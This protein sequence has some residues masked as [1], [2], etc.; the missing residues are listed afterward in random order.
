[1]NTQRI[2]KIL[3]GAEWPAVILAGIVAFAAIAYAAFSVGHLFSVYVKISPLESG[4]AVV[5]SVGMAVGLL[6]VIVTTDNQNAR[7]LGSILLIAWVLLVLSMVALDSVM[8]AA[9][10]QSP[11]ALQQIGRIVAALLP[12]LAL[13]GVV[14]MVIALHDKTTH[15]RAAGASSRY[16]SFAA[17]GVSIGA[18]SFAAFYF[19][20]SRGI[21]PVL[22]VLCAALLES[23][24]LWSYLAL[25][26]S[27]DRGDRF[28]VRMWSLCTL[29]FGLFIAAVS[30]ET[31]SA[32]GKIDVPIVK[33]LGEVGAT[34]YVSAVGL[35]VLLT[36]AVHLL[37]R[38]IDDVP[39]E[40]QA[41]KPFAI[42]TAESIRA[43]RAGVGEIKAALAG[44]PANNAPQLPAGITLADDGAKDGNWLG[45]FVFVFNGESD[46]D[47][48]EEI[49]SRADELMGE[50]GMRVKHGS[51]IGLEFW[52]FDK[53]T[54]T[55]T[56][57]MVNG[58]PMRFAL[59]SMTVE[60]SVT[61]FTRAANGSVTHAKVAADVFFKGGM[62]EAEARKLVAGVVKPDSELMVSGKKVSKNGTIYDET[63]IEVSPAEA[64]DLMRRHR[65]MLDREAQRPKS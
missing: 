58:Q 41:G 40:G 16:I 57:K 27:R 24:F 55:S 31:L 38:A 8:R 53:E 34:L 62:T 20:S 5:S 21:D 26:N 45:K 49:K 33:A 48:G 59:N 54:F 44:K 52:V 42:R 7:G 30:V 23:S 39:G 61:G 64:D 46:Y 18:S 4:L 65:E 1:M 35:T 22:A 12:A 36:I 17:K 47:E 25:K 9:L 29:L 43:T 56:S 60:C 13:A 37:T 50:I 51:P 32:L 10:V 28:D 14:G 3:K 63:G 2:Q 11:A 19:G 15:K 6:L